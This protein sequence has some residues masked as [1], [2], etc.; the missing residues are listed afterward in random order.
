MIISL[1]YDLAMDHPGCHSFQGIIRHLIYKGYPDATE[2]GSSTEKSRSRGFMNSQGHEIE[3]VEEQLLVNTEL[4]LVNFI[5]DYR[6][7]RTG[8]PSSTY[9]NLNWNPDFS[10][11]EQDMTPQKLRRWKSDFTIS[12]LY[13]LVNTYAF[14]RLQNDRPRMN[15][16]EKLNWDW[17]DT[18]PHGV[19]TRRMLWGPMD[20]AH[21]ITV[22]AMQ[23]PGSAIAPEIKPHHVFQLQI[24]VDSMVSAKLWNTQNVEHYRKKSSSVAWSSDLRAAWALRCDYY[25]STNHLLQILKDD[26]QQR[27]YQRWQNTILFLQLQMEEVLTLGKTPLTSN[28]T[29]P[30]SLFSNSSNNG[31]WF[32]SP[33]LCGTGM[34]EMLNVA[35]K[36]GAGFWERS[37]PVMTFFHLYNVLLE[38][39][40]LSGPIESVEN[41]IDVFQESIFG[42]HRPRLKDQRCNN[43]VNAYARAVGVKTE[44]LINEG[45]NGSRRRTNSVFNERIFRSQVKPVDHQSKF[46]KPGKLFALGQAGWMANRIDAKKF[47][48]LTTAPQDAIGFLEAVK[49]DIVNDLT[50]STPP[51]YVNFQAI[52]A[53]SMEYFQALGEAI[54]VTSRAQNDTSHMEDYSLQTDSPQ[55]PDSGL[56]DAIMAA[57]LYTDTVSMQDGQGRRLNSPMLARMGEVTE[58]FWTAQCDEDGVRA[59]FYLETLPE[60]NDEAIQEAQVELQSFL[61]G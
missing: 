31:L 13:D 36:L 40:H 7:Y 58:R 55:R 23:K 52:M 44:F 39:H 57:A 8:K 56:A 38:N 20:F 33:Y 25:I 29:G 14:I 32:Y 35:Y 19:W 45:L 42:S 16:P 3:L 28:D 10:D 12:W 2:N 41:I 51:A 37:V 4:D 15:K 27:R 18:S 47:A 43:F 5:G 53:I 1:Q 26:E 9:A 50:S 60:P 61:L 49:I 54:G 24:A 6:K 30:T 59:F 48:S 34:V 11:R 22:L 21:D 46:T 17:R